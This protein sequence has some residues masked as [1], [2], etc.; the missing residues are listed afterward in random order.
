MTFK[1][2]HINIDRLSYQKIV[3]L[4]MLYLRASHNLQ[5]TQEQKVH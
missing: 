4:E 5:L 3:N 1:F 2:L